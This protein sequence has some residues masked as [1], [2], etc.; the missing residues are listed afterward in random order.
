[1]KVTPRT[2]SHNPPLKLILGGKSGQPVSRTR[3]EE[4]TYLNLKFTAALNRQARI[5]KQARGS[6]PRREW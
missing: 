4:C 2:S 3:E 1:M 5:L 6:R